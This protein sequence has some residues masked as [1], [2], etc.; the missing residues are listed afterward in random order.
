MGKREKER[1]ASMAASNS[2]TSLESFQHEEIDTAFFECSGLLLEDGEDFFGGKFANVL[3][4]SE[5]ADGAGNQD[6]VLGSFARFA[7]NFYAAMIEVRR[8]GLPCRR[9][10]ACGGWRRKYW[11][12]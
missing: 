1:I 4:D 10:R 11:S 7:G 12:R 8:R 2:S 6:F 9:G 5:R 3:D